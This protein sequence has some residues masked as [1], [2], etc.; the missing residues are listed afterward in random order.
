MWSKQNRKQFLVDNETKWYPYK[1]EW[2]E[3]IGVIKKSIWI[4]AQSIGKKGDKI[5]GRTLRLK[6][7]LLGH[8]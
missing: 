6:S 3:S 8:A 1:F 4:L 5:L 2:G 7:C